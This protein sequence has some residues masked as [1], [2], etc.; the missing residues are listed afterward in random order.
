MRRYIFDLDLLTLV[1]WTHLEPDTVAVNIVIDLGT[2]MELI[3]DMQNVTFEFLAENFATFEVWILNIPFAANFE[4]PG[5]H[6]LERRNTA[7]R[8]KLVWKPEV[9]WNLARALERTSKGTNPRTGAKGV[10]HKM[11]ELFC[12]LFLL[13]SCWVWLLAGSGCWRVFFVFPLPFDWEVSGAP[14]LR[15]SSRSVIFGM[16]IMVSSSCYHFLFRTSS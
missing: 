1:I 14:Y 10:D 2:S 9:S 11:A 15:V 8:V 5:G 3:K 6:R 7:G 16:G 4:S 13:L 12:C